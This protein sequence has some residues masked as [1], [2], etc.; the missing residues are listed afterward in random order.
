MGSSTSLDTIL[1]NNY[2]NDSILL[3]SNTL[4]SYSYV[5]YICYLLLTILV[6][7]LYIRFI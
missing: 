2:N 1:K 4:V 3:D 5:N 7:L 6:I